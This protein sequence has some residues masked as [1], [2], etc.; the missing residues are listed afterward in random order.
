MSAVLILGVGVFA[1]V[2]ILGLIMLWLWWMGD[3]E[4]WGD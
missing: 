1:G 2:G 4:T 3:K